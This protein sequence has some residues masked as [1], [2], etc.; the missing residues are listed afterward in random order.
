MIYSRVSVVHFGAILVADE[1][2]PVTGKG[3]VDG[4]V[5]RLHGEGQLARLP[6]QRADHGK[7][8]FWDGRD[9]RV[10]VHGAKYFLLQG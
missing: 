2:F 5:Q 7:V 8:D 1:K 6:N 4:R 10:E 9:A 3:Q